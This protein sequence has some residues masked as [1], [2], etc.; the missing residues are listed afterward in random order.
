[1]LTNNLFKILGTKLVRVKKALRNFESSFRGKLNDFGGKIFTD[2]LN[3]ILK[4]EPESEIFIPAPNQC[5]TDD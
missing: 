1:M 5:P 2:A 3:T 4:L